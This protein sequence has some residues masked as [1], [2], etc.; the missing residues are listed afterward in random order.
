MAKNSSLRILKF[1]FLKCR[2]S[3]PFFAKY[4]APPVRVSVVSL[5]AAQPAGDRSQD[6]LLELEVGDG[7]QVDTLHVE[8]LEDVI[9]PWFYDPILDQSEASI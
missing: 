7:L 9:D 1:C 3:S 4:S 2:F 6:E 5:D 8:S